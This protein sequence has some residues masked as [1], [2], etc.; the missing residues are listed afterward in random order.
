MFTESLRG[1]GCIKDLVDEV[2]FIALDEKEE[3]ILVT[4]TD[5]T[6]RLPSWFSDNA[7]YRYLPSMR[8][9][10]MD[11]FQS[12]DYFLVLRCIWREVRD[13]TTPDNVDMGLERSV[14]VL[15][16]QDVTMN[17]PKRFQW[18]PISSAVIFHSEA[19]ARQAIADQLQLIRSRQEP[20]Q[21]VPWARP[22][23]FKITSQWVRE[24]LTACGCGV[25]LDISQVSVTP[26]G[27]VLTIQT[28]SCDFF[29]K[30][31]PCFNNEGAINDFLSSVAPMRVQKPL[32]VDYE[33]R[34][35]ISR[36]HGDCVAFQKLSKPEKRQFLLDVAEL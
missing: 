13:L 27:T 22:G 29:L 10:M 35:F 8:Q 14:V 4:K 16:C 18:V 32:A 19:R 2:Q 15:E 17:I 36:D 9:A 12:K 25:I 33:K 20:V 3:H 5:G 21:R 30:A 1:M 23:W 31:S 6:L 24:H 34:M 26:W 7:L 28:E 11:I